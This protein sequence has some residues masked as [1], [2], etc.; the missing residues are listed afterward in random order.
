MKNKL[1][2]SIARLKNAAF[3]A[4]K[5]KKS[6]GTLADVVRGNGKKC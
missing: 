4:M 3:E 5:G 6:S 1:E 2:R